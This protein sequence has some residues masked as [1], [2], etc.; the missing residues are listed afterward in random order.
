MPSQNEA[1]LTIASVHNS[2]SPESGEAAF[3]PRA[4]PTGDDLLATLGQVSFS[5]D[6]ASDAL[7]WGGNVAAVLRDI[8]PSALT[9]A[10]EFSKLIEP[11]RSIRNDVVLNA[12]ASD[13]G[14]GVPYQI[15]YGVR[16]STSVPV[17]WIDECGRWFAGADGKPSHVR[18]IIRIN[19]ERHARD[20]QLLKLSQDDPL[21]GAF[22]RTRLTAAL[23]EAIEEA[24][25]FRSSFAFMLV[26]IDHLAQINDAFG[27]EVAD[28]VILEAQSVFGCGCVA[29]M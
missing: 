25:R 29:A 22:N 21:T 5:W 11:S 28:Q 20:E 12:T 26:G 7:H 1:P 27:Y 19:N 10:G 4:Q 8:S 6:I 2:R 18:G 3:A 14:E 9:R 13:A 15:E 17:L 16:G 23:A 24:N